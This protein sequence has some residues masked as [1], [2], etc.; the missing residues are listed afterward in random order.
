M[1]RILHLIGTVDPAAG[2]PT[3]VIRML[4]KHAPPDF[5]S[6]VATIDDP[7]ASFLHE[8]PC[9]VHAL[10][11][12][13]KQWYVPA[14]RDW[15]IV[16]R[17]RYDGVIVHGLWEY[18]GVAARIALHGKVPYAVFPHGMLDPY[19]RRAHPVKH[20]KKCLYWLTEEYWTLRR[21]HRVLFTA[22]AER[23]LALL[24]FTPSRWRSAVTPIG[25]ESPPPYTQEQG[26][27]FAAAVPG[28]AGHRFLLFLGRID[29][30]KGCDLLLDAFTA[31]EGA[32]ANDPDL[33]LVMAGPDSNGWSQQ[34]RQRLVTSPF[35]DRVHW[36]GMLRGDAK[37]G[38]LASCEAFVLTSHQ[39][40][41][42]VAVAEAMAASRPVLL[43][44]PVN[45]AQEIADAGGALVEADTPRGVSTL[46]Q[47]WISLPSDE[48]VQMGVKARKM[49]EERFDM[50]RNAQAILRV[51]Q[52][53]AEVP[54]GSP[55][56]GTS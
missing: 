5:E 18:T 30:K 43:T 40:N 44:F 22:T 31:P 33:H 53:E 37:Y 6:E 47:R 16:H 50:P 3:E 32:A 51:F 36:P 55:V 11:S 9:T 15:L 38:A 42:G 20:L 21:A 8:M 45:I 34:L 4:V 49:F 19:F 56:E 13:R 24:T 26:D 27:A 48:R 12:A 41:F 23:D 54:S 25:C 14:L 52:H 28:V 2:G 10:G 46:L 35:A 39:E 7:F 29:P 17:D 1:Q